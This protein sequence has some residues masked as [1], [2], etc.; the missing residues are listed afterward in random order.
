MLTSPRT[1]ML[2]VYPNCCNRLTVSST[3]VSRLTLLDTHSTL[4]LHAPIRL[5][6]TYGLVTSFL[7]TRWSASRL[8]VPRSPRLLSILFSAGLGVGCLL[9]HFA[10]DPQSSV[11]CRDLDS[12]GDMSV[13]GLVSLYDSTFTGLLD[14]HCPL[15]TVRHKVQRSRVR[16]YVHCL[17]RRDWTLLICRTSDLCLT[18]LLVPSY[19]NA[20]FWLDCRPS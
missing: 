15:V 2:S 20:W 12:P 11:L 8:K 19:W 4:S 14:K 13:D 1:P 16:W 6:A 18:C 7:T 17:R 9:T 3:S 10:V 5:S